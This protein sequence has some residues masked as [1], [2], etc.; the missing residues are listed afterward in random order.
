LIRLVGFSILVCRVD[1]FGSPDVLDRRRLWRRFAIC[2]YR[3]DRGQQR[4]HQDEEYRQIHRLLSIP[5]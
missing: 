3:S 4:H 1:G 2:I 5:E